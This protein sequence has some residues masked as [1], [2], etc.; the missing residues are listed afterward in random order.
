MNTIQRLTK[1]QYALNGIFLHRDSK[2]CLTLFFFALRRVV[3]L[4]GTEGVV[5]FPPDLGRS[6]FSGEVNFPIDLTYAAFTVD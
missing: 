3:F 2:K 1:T 5:R 6:V 4:L